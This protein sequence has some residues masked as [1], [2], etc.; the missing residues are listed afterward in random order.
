[1][2]REVKMICKRF[3]NLPSAEKAKCFDERTYS[4]YTGSGEEI[5]SNI[6]DLPEIFTVMKDLP[7]DDARVRLRW[8][9]HGPCSWLNEDFKAIVNS[10]MESLAESSRMLMHLIALGLELEVPAELTDFTEEGW[11]YMRILHYPPG[12]GEGVENKLR[13]GIGQAS[14]ELT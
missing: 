3:F 2:F 11:H 4:G 12:K 14:V 5:T 8:P 1:M 7:P 10:L 6:E 9:C 13:R